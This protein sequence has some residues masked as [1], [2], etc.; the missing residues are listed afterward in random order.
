MAE[1]ERVTLPAMRLRGVR[2]EVAVGEGENNIPGVFAEFQEHLKAAGFLYAAPEIG[3]YR[4]VRDGV[5][6]VTVGAPI[7]RDVPG[8]EVF[9][10]PGSEALKTVHHGDF[11]GLPG[12]FGMVQAQVGERGLAFGTYGREVYRVIAKD[13]ALNEVDVFLDV[14]DEKAGKDV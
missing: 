12:T 8:L 4:F 11:T 5:M 14:V 3:L 2:R 6:E 7:D 13:I 1:I 10:V 9:E